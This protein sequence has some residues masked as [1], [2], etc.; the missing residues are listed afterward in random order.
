MQFIARLPLAWK[1][2]IPVL[3]IFVFSI[4]IAFIKPQYAL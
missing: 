3:V 2:S 4:G 1:V